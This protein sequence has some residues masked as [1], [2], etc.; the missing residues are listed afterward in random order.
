MI[1]AGSAAAEIFVRRVPEDLS[2]FLEELD[3]YIATGYT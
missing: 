1:N 2:F 3:A